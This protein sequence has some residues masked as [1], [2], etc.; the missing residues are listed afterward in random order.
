MWLAFRHRTCRHPRIDGWGVQ[1]RWDVFA[2]G[3]AR[4]P[5]DHAGRTAAVRRPQR[6]A[7]RFPARPGR[8]RLLC[9]RQRQPRLDAAEHGRPQPERRRQPFRRPAAAGGREVPRPARAGGRAA[10]GPSARSRADRPHPRLQDRRRRQD[11]P[12][13]PRRPAPPHRYLSRRHRRRLPDGPAPLRPRRRRARLLHRLRPQHGRRR[14]VLR[15]GARRRPTIFTPFRE[16]SS[17]CTAT[18]AACRTPTAIAMCYGWSAATARCPCR[19]VCPSRWPRTPAKCT[20]TCAR[21]TASVPRTLPPPTRAPTGPNTTTLWSRWSRSSRA[22]PPP[23]RRP[24]PRRPRT[25][26]NGS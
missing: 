4:R 17:P 11:L 7:R 18:N 26:Q 23:P 9:L 14:R 1:A 24:A 25:L 8:Q 12:H 19:S 20:P 13:L 5:L 3:L 15:G 22:M 6:H 21:R 16:R 10:A 2:D